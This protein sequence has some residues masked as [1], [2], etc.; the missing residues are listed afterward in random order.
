MINNGFPPHGFPPP[1]P[2]PYGPTQPV[3]IVDHMLG[4]SYYVVKTVYMNLQFLRELGDALNRY[5]TAT[6]AVASHLSTLE[7]LGNNMS[8]LFKIGVDLND[9]ELLSKNM[10]RFE[11]LIADLD[12]REVD[13]VID[14]GLIGD[15]RDTAFWGGGH[16]KIVADN[17]EDV[18]LVGDNIDAVK[19]LADQMDD[20]TAL[21]ENIS[22][23]KNTVVQKAAQ[24]ATNTATVEADTEEVRSL[25]RQAA[26]DAD[27]LAHIE[28]LA[29]EAQQNASE[30]A[31]QACLS[32][33][34]A[35]KAANKAQRILEAKAQADWSEPD[36]E[37]NGYVQNRTHYPVYTSQETVEDVLEATDFTVLSGESFATVE[38][39]LDLDED[40]SYIV[41]F[42]G[43]EFTVPGS[44]LLTGL[45]TTKTTTVVVNPNTSGSICGCASSQRQSKIE[46]TAF[47]LRV[48]PGCCNTKLYAEEGD[49]SLQIQKI[50]KTHTHIGN[51]KLD[52]VFLP[53]W[54]LTQEEVIQ[55]CT[56]APVYSPA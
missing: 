13:N 38:P 48:V 56:N 44:V 26:D 19:N 29:R 37:E 31:D 4:E 22:G 14:Y 25:A 43:K 27:S 35:V 49:H 34:Q 55:I 3:Q 23:A 20:A 11:V 54:E 9:L 1:P 7:V 40:T 5:E 8:T 41:V 16:I 30:S 17:I 2:P 51:K 28:G 15:G 10:D 42:D 39:C 50:V 52:P 53:L 32:A 6:S 46:T 24:V 18:V 45:L 21:W 33:S 12:G 36:E 47:G